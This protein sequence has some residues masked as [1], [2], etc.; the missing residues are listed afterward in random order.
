LFLC[1][2]VSPEVLDNASHASMI[3]EEDDDDDSLS[4]IDRC[5]FTIDDIK[6]R[7]FRHH[8]LFNLSNC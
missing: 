6:F 5:A 8:Y 7:S 3:S 1:D 2:E 4:Q